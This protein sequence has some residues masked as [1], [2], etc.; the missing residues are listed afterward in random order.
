ME[1]LQTIRECFAYFRTSSKPSISFKERFYWVVK[2][3]GMQGVAIE[4][5]KDKQ[6][7][8]TFSR[9]AYYTK[10]FMLN[11]QEHNLLMLVSNHPKLHDDFAL[12]CA[13]FLEKV[14]DSESYQEIQANPISWWHAMK[15]LLGNANIEKAAYSVLAE[16]VS[17]YYLLSKGE[18][19]TWA[20]PA[21]GTV[22]LACASGDGYEVKS[23]TARYGTQITIS[24]QYQLR[25]NT[26]L[27]YRFEPSLKGVSI[28]QMVE[29]L[30]A[31]GVE[32]D[33]LERALKKLGYRAGSEIREKPYVLL[34]ALAY[35]VNEAFPK[36]TPESFVTGQLPSYIPSI[37]YTV[38]LEGLP[39]TVL[40]TGI[41]RA[42]RG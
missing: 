17:Y 19:V 32:E 25:A 38:E 40:D 18:R 33:E 6:V 5:P 20:G 15:E 36:I 11:G 29:Q 31:K 8:E 37:T 39:C 2:I 9:I 27:F 4:V 3:G 16:L 1:T 21:G 41:M 26:L 12:I 35:E 28:Q 10:E 13:G 34:E 14:L 23:T 7:N 42:V 30:I 24:S 22:D